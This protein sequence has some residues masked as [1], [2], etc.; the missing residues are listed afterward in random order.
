VNSDGRP[1]FETFDYGLVVFPADAEKTLGQTIQE[2]LQLCQRTVHTPLTS[3]F[4]TT[5]A[6]ADAVQGSSTPL[7]W[8]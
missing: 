2:R 1:P 3:N 5:C 4:A 8:V 6:N 7:S